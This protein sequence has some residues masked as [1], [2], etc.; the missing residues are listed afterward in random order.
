ME[1]RHRLYIQVDY[2][3]A[4]IDVAL[5]TIILDLLST[6]YP[7]IYVDNT[8]SIVRYILCVEVPGTW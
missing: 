1:T 8:L 7:Y 3:P 6:Y 5:T 4:T 2:V